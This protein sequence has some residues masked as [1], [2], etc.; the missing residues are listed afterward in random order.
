MRIAVGCRFFVFAIPQKVPGTPGFCGQ[1]GQN[2]TVFEDLGAR[3]GFIPQAG[4]RRAVE[5]LFDGDQS[6]FII[7][8]FLK[9]EVMASKFD[10]LEPPPLNILIFSRF[11][12]KKAKKLSVGTEFAYI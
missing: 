9:Y 1:M 12:R 10:I 11:G 7:N 8:N 5:G 4:R 3:W 2:D 6:G